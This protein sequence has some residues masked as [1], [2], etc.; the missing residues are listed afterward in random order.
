VK[1]RAEAFEAC[2][3]GTESCDDNILL[4]W[5]RLSMV[6]I[7]ADAQEGQYKGRL[8]DLRKSALS[9]FRMHELE[10]VAA[11]KVNQLTLLNKEKS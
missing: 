6:K 4:T 2:I 1:S 11:L 7:K 10:M 9:I 8:A 5:N 3:E